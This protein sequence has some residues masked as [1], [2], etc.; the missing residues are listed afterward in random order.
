MLRFQLP[1]DPV[2]LAIL[3]YAI[4]MILDELEDEGTEEDYWKAQYSNAAKVFTMPLARDTLNA[5]LEATKAPGLYQ[6]TDYHWL[7]LY[8]AL[9]VQIDILNDLASEQPTGLW[10][11]GPYWIGQ[12][13]LGDAI[14]G[15]FWDI[16]FLIEGELIAALTPEQRQSMGMNPETLSQPRHGSASRRT[17][18]RA[19]RGGGARAERGAGGTGREHHQEGPELGRGDEG[20]LGCGHRAE[21]MV[22]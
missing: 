12:V 5:L 11:V 19:L 20:E 14:D 18:D 8:D 3:H 10:R 7:L 13:D 17:E 21:A 4:E 9:R 6:I 22:L 1:P 16:D 2:F 15:V